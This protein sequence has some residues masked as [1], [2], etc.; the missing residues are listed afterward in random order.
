MKK[1]MGQRRLLFQHFAPSTPHMQDADKSKLF[2]STS[3]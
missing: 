2:T 3:D 1:L